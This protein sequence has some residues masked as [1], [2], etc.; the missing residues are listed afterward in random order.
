MSP[1]GGRRREFPPKVRKAAFARCC[2][3]GSKPGIPQCENCGNVLV[4][5][6]IEFEHLEADGLA[7]EPTLQNCG[8]WCARPCSKTKTTKVDNPRMAKA[9]AVLRATYGLRP[10]RKK[11]QS[12]GFAKTRPQRSATRAIERKTY[13]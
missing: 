7:G 1:R 11:I 3:N 4:A 2:T 6:N 12:P 9:D 8:V 10:T 5:G 13:L